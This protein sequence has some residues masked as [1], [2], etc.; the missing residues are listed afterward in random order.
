MCAQHSEWITL[1]TCH[2]I[3]SMFVWLTQ[4]RRD[5]TGLSAWPSGEAVR[6]G[7]KYRGRSRRL[8]H[9]TMIALCLR[10]VPRTLEL[11]DQY[12][13]PVLP[14]AW[15]LACWCSSGLGLPKALPCLF[16]DQTV[17]PAAL[18][19]KL[20]DP[21]PA[22]QWDK[23][24]RRKEESEGTWTTRSTCL[25]TEEHN[26][27]I[28]SDPEEFWRYYL[29]ELLC[30]QRKPMGVTVWARKRSRLRFVLSAWQQWKYLEQVKQ[31]QEQSYP[32]ASYTRPVIPRILLRMESANRSPYVEEQNGWTGGESDRSPYVEEQNVWTVGESD[33]GLGVQVMLKTQTSAALKSQKTSVAMTSWLQLLLRRDKPATWWKKMRSFSR[34][35]VVEKPWRENRPL[36]S[37]NRHTPERGLSS[38]TFVEKPSREKQSLYDI[39]RHIPEKSLISVTRVERPSEEGLHWWH[40]QGHTPE[41]SP[42]SVFIVGKCSAR[43]D[44][45]LCDMKW[46]TLERSLTN[47][48]C[49]K[50]PSARDHTLCDI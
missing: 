48:T 43:I 16:Y 25:T 19:T 2:V 29:A 22:R 3:V 14:A 39:S 31:H 46:R 33:R 35:K 24:V 20:V 50:K 13:Y 18:N 44:H 40:M 41:R 23:E 28:A 26:L 1:L 34:L 37:T 47:V 42:T 6:S 17:K 9:A 12:R 30:V 27:F 10:H 36:C 11:A 32:K 49:V 7:R 5:P 21:P 8:C 4:S 38:V 15:C 45:T